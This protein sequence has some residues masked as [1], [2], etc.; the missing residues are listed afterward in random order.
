MAVP[1]TLIADAIGLAVQANELTLPAGSLS[2]ATN[3]EITRDGIVEV[4]RGFQDFSTNLPDLNPKQI[5]SIGDVAY[6]NLDGG[7]WYY[8]TADGGWY[9]KRGSFG[10]KFTT[11]Y[12]CA[13][14][15]GYAYIISL[16]HVIFKVNLSTGSS[17]ILAGRLGATGST[18]G[19][20][21]AARFNNPS[22]ITT[23]GT[24]LF[25]SDNGNH[26]IRKIVI[27]SAVVTTL[28]GTAGASGSTDATGSSARF[29][30]PF[31]ITTD[32]TNLFV[33]DFGNETIRKIVIS[34]AVVTT[35]AGTAGAPGSTDDTGA[36]AR[37]SGPAGIT[38]DNTNLYVTEYGNDTIRKIVIATAVVTTLAGTAGAPGTTDGTGTA[39][40][41]SNPTGMA[42]IG[43]NLYVCDYNNHTI[44]KVVISSAVV[45]TFAG[46]AGSNDSVDGIST[47]ARFNTPSGV[48]TDGTNLYVC[49]RTNNQ[50]RKIYVGSQYVVTLSDSAVSA[51]PVMPNPF[52]AG[53]IFGS[54]VATAERRMHGAAMNGNTYF[55]SQKGIIKSESASATIK[56]AGLP[57]CLD[58]TLSLSSAGTPVLLANGYRRAYRGCWA[59]R[60]ANNNL[61]LGPPSSRFDLANGAGATRDVSV[62]SY[63]PP[64]V[65]TSHIF[66]LYATEIVATATDPGD[67]QRQVYKVN[68]TS[69]DITNGYLT[70][71]DI[72]PDAFRGDDLY[73]NQNQEGIANQNDRP[74]LARD[75]CTFRRKMLYANFTEPH[76]M[77][78][79]M[80]GTSGMTTQTITIGGVA[81]TAGTAASTTTGTFQVFKPGGGGYTDQ[82]TQSLNVEYTA[83]S[84]VYIINQYAATTGFRAYYESGPDDAPGKIL[85]EEI[86]VGS[87]AFVAICSASAMG[88][89]FSPPIPTTGSTYTSTAETR[90]NR[91]RVSKTDEPESCPRG[92]DII[93][94][95][96]DEAIERIIPLR[97]S[98]LVIKTHSIWRLTEA[99]PGEQPTFV[100]NTVSISG[101]DSAA[102]LNNTVFMLSDQGFVAVTD[103]G[104]QLGG[105]PIEYH[106]VTGLE[107]AD[108]PDHDLFV[109]IGHEQ[110]R[111]YICTAWDA[112]EDE[113]TCYM[114]SPI[115]N[116]GKGAWTKRTLT[117]S[118]FAVLNNRLL[119]ALDNNNGHVLRQRASLRD[120]LPW[121]R[122][123]CEDDCTFNVASATVVGSGEYTLVGTLTFGVD[124][125]ET[126]SAMDLY[127]WKFYDGTSHYVVTASSYNGGTWTLTVFGDSSNTPNTGS[128][129]I[130]RP[131]QWEVEWAPIA[132]G[133]PTETKVFGDVIVKAATHS[134]Y[135]LDFSFANQVDTKTVPYADDWESNPAA[136]RVFVPYKYGARATSTDNDFR[137]TPGS[138]ILFNAIRATPP[139]SRVYGE[140]L[141]VRVAGG[142]AEGYV[143][144]KTL[145]VQT[146][147]TA[148]NKG[149]P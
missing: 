101:R 26:T 81:Y 78:L 44:R 87:S 66:L 56:P 62:V 133:N 117:A 130:R 35:L 32:G 119:Y 29:N 9:R 33:S 140:H 52:M 30:A 97:S 28:A 61:I 134:A 113:A 18:D 72:T 89:S 1:N 83:K 53:M 108:A 68:P 104:V 82:G 106:T 60:D 16:N 125:G 75:I 102:V 45:T 46:T 88:N 147:G 84:L 110:R 143:G 65:T 23:D 128:Q 43:A 146:T 124:Y 57:R 129:T 31:G 54:D 55:T 47:T 93:I 99:E 42:I 105:R 148:S 3:V 11:P 127:G 36:A 141:S 41:F 122:D 63:L 2:I 27:S 115:A 21:A 77:E 85:I 138:P 12:D 19:T 139:P 49:D 50:F 91:I 59:I 109:G 15:G 51:A 118:A 103:N 144:I 14:T 142:V 112:A 71:V 111:F 4:A 132:G 114:F 94:G 38:T 74:P 10:S 70:I 121:Y 136:D 95:G 86:G 67:E 6:L 13:I 126:Q 39:A 8:S 5:L 107:V 73:T 145:M 100:D 37:F 79:Q 7:L 40:R 92:N 64:E 17:V 90:V 48:A 34:S 120:D 123:Y 137:S 116:K 98:V 149:R 96:E 131:V 25:V 80:L 58:L 76:R 135:A 69:T 20:G 22:G 24:N